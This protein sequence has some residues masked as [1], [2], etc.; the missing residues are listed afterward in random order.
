MKKRQIGFVA[1]VLVVMF[2]VV[3]NHTSVT[4]FTDIPIDDS[5][6]AVKDDVATQKSSSKKHSSSRA[7]LQKNNAGN[8][9][10][11]AQ[12]KQSI[13]TEKRYYLLSEPN[14]PYYSSS[15]ALQ[16]I[17]APAAWEVNEDSSDVTIAVLD[18][19]FALN[20]QDLSGRWYLNPGE[21]GGGKENNG[22]DDDGNG[23]I[24]DHRGWDFYAM[25]KTPQAGS[26]DPGGEGVSHGT[27]VAGLA[28][29]TSN[30]GVGIASVARN[31]I[32]MPLQVMGDDGSGYSSSIVAAVY[33][34]VDQ[35][36]DVIN[37]SL[38]TAGNDPAV[39]VAVDYA[40]ANGVVVV[41]AAGNCGNNTQ[42]V[43]AGQPAGVVTF[44]A[45]YDRVV[46]VGA[47]AQNNTRANFSSYGE[48]LDM[49]APGSGSL[50]STTWTA[51]NGTSA[52]KTTMHGTSYASP[53]V[54]SS[55]ALIRS[56]RP[57]T[58]VDDVRALLLASTQKV[59][60][61]SSVFYTQNY[62]H[63]QL[64]IGRAMTIASDLNNTAEQVPVVMQ[65]GNSQAEKRYQTADSLG[66]GCQ[67]P[68][69]TWCTVWLRNT[70]RSY[71]R[72]L[73]YAQTNGDNEHG[74]TWSGS[75]LQKG[76]WSIRGVQGER[77]SD[78]PILLFSK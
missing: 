2:A 10:K 16:N 23:Y 48:R 11:Q 54:A 24:D 8:A 5:H 45:S 6:T 67:V 25:D 27:E 14:D 46:A 73:P 56:I 76:E 78:T 22:I 18:S 71:D 38:G 62:G 12:I 59:S 3:L 40:V 43:C 74:W 1:V 35:G 68:S 51:G 77:L 41:A 4:T 28:G 69:G 9:P 55:A 34:A 13:G 21:S 60:A 64:N 29:A 63:G 49:M 19:G 58:S 61:M 15:W 30:N 66:S 31:P 32:I 33:Y 72:F 75:V 17:Q 53:I 44:P 47:L 26:V 42:G 39:R 52:Y 70:T 50:T 37:M 65:A 57:E 7:D 36:A 20:H